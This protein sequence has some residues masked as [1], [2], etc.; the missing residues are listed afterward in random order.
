ME[1]REIIG[2]DCAT[3]DEKVAVARSRWTA[4]WC[5]VRDVQVCSRQDPANTILS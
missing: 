4:E 5:E 2:V 1:E 3:K